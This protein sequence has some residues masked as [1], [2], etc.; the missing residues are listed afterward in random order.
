MILEVIDAT[1]V[2]FQGWK[3]LTIKDEMEKMRVK[4][5]ELTKTD[6][7]ELM[8]QQ[9]K[10]F[11]GHT[12]RVRKQYIAVKLMKEKLPKKRMPLSRWT[13]RKTIVVRHWKKFKAHIGTSPL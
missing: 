13:L 12:E 7:K 1:E 6:F 5:I 2:K 11:V 8:N 4:D 3:R 9:Y 10:D